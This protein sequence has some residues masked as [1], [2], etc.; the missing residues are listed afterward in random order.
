[1]K[2][3]TLT[4]VASAVYALS[5]AVTVL[6]AMAGQLGSLSLATVTGWVLAA[7]LAGYATIALLLVG[8]TVHWFV[9]D[10]LW[11]MR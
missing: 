3:W 1:M 10:V 8:G 2:N 5:L 6:C 4:Q 11:K 9:K 7:W